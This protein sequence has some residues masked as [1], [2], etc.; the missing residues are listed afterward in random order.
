M[1]TVTTVI[2][3]QDSVRVGEGRIDLEEVDVCGCSPPVQQ[4]DGRGT[5]T[6]VAHEELADAVDR[7]DVTRR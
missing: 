3:R 7:D 2:E 1:S 5:P 6:A 4:E